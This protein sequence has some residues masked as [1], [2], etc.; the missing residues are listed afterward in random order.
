MPLYERPE[1]IAR[2]DRV[3]SILSDMFGVGLIKTPPRYPLDWSVVRDQRVIAFAEIKCRLN[4]R[5]TRQWLEDNNFNMNL[6][7]LESMNSLHR[8]SG[9]PCLL[10]ICTA[11]GHLMLMHC[12]PGRRFDCVLGGRYDRGTSGI[13]TQVSIPMSAFMHVTTVE[14]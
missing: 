12:D 1:D 3:A 9:L 5:Y 8:E 2:E 4:K 11:D 7:K 13:R 10:F 6:E 14:I